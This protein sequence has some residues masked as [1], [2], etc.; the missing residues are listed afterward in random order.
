MNLKM[1]TWKIGA[2]IGGV[3][4]LISFVLWIMSS[5]GPSSG[6]NPPIIFM[7]LTLPASIP[8]LIAYYLSEYEL[9]DISSTF[10]VC[11][12]PLFGIVIGAL[13]GQRYEKWKKTK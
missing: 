12:I 3:W 10:L 11:S 13:I 6:A 8:I 2:L 5:G 1:K 7:I 9:I 4:G